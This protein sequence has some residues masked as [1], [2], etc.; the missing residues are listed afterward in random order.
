MKCLHNA[1]IAAVSR[2]DFAY[3]LVDL[4]LSDSSDAWNRIRSSRPIFG[5]PTSAKS[6]QN[7]A[8][9]A[10][11]RD[12]RR[13]CQQKTTSAATQLIYLLSDDLRQLHNFWAIEKTPGS[14][15]SR[16]DRAGWLQSIRHGAER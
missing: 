9:I 3:C 10:I 6:L 16:L 13:T 4:W 1:P 14:R 7:C 12:N 15:A 11:H 8:S 5:L 2:A